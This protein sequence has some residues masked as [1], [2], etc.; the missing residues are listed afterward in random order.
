MD[1]SQAQLTGRLAGLPHG[2]LAGNRQDDVL[3]RPVAVAV[4]REYPQPPVLPA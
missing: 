1:A 2:R 3:R 4:R